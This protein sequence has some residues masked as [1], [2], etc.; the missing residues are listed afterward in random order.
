MDTIA[1]RDLIERCRLFLRR[2]DFVSGYFPQLIMEERA[3][4]YWSLFWYFV[5]N[6]DTLV[7]NFTEGPQLD[8]SFQSALGKMADGDLKSSLQLF[9]QET[10]AVVPRH[11]IDEMYRGARVEQAEF[12][13]CGPPAAAQY[14]NMID[15]KTV[16]P[17]R[18]CLALNRARG[19]TDTLDRLAI[20]FGRSVQLL[21]DLLDLNDDLRHGKTYI[22]REELE[23][24]GI[25]AADIPNNLDRITKLR[26]KWA[27]AN[28][29]PAYAAASELIENNF[30]LA[31]RSWLESAC[32]LIA[33]H[34]IV[35]LTA[36]VLNDNLLFAHYMGIS[37]L[38]FDLFPGSELLK[39]RLY[40]KPLVKCLQRFK[41]FEMARTRQLYDDLDVELGT[42]REFS[43]AFGATFDD[44]PLPPDNRTFIDVGNSFGFDTMRHNVRSIL[45]E[46]RAECYNEL[47][48]RFNR[49]PARELLDLAGHAASFID[50]VRMGYQAG[51]GIA[52]PRRKA[53]DTVASLFDLGID[54]FSLAAQHQFA[55][56]CDMLA[57]LERRAG[58]A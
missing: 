11:L 30:V 57:W 33:E 23:L 31:A 29:L 45:A 1:S 48:D 12:V 28:I 20:G 26:C 8:E 39:Y 51:N 49:A 34:K 32:R 42:L 54:C 2:N 50:A 21:D 58:Q 17:V 40:H 6:L 46:S 14:L 3:S 38:P 7:D 43:L 4:E 37:T 47:V 13:A 9:L 36:S 53:P 15:L 16:A 27:L 35:P 24:L 10:V 55:F 41:V 19:D 22:T 25:S 18:I 5:R 44:R 56:Q 52:A